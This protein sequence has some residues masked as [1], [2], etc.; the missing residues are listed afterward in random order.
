MLPQL[1]GNLR[2][3]CIAPEPPKGSHYDDIVLAL[4]D[5]IHKYRIC[6][7]KHKG[8]IGLWDSLDTTEE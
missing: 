4:G 5:A 3:P 8:I 7:I 6:N 2:E 1:P